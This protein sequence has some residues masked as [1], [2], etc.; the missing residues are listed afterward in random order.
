[1]ARMDIAKVYVSIENIDTISDRVLLWELCLRH[2]AKLVH[3]NWKP[4]RWVI[5]MDIDGEHMVELR[6][7]E[8]AYELIMGEGDA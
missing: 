5:E 1:M 8:K 7:S 4:A 6:L 2:K 3:S